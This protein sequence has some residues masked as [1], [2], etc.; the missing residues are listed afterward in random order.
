MVKKILI[1]ANKTVFPSLDG[2]SLAIQKLAIN[3]ACQNYLIDLVCVAKD[4]HHN[5]ISTDHKPRKNIRQRV[6]VK[7]MDL[8][9]I[10]F[11]KSIANK[12]SYQSLRFYD[13][14]IQHEI[15]KLINTNTYKAIVFESVFTTI[16]LNKLKLK[17]IEKIIFRAHNI[18]HKIWEDLARNSVFK[19]TIFLLL[20]KQIKRVEDAIPK[21]VDYIFTLSDSDQEYF[22]KIHPTKTIHIP[23]TFEVEKINTL[24]IT[25]SIAHLGAMDWKPNIEGID[26]FLE[27]VKPQIEDEDIKIYIAGKNMPKKYFKHQNT[28]TIIDG[29][30]DNAK[31]YI[32]NKE[33]IFV[34][35]FSGSGIRIKILE[36]MALGIPII[37]T[38]KG[39]HGIPYENKKNILIADNA[40]EFQEA[41]CLLIRNKQLAKNIGYEGQKLILNHFSH[42]SVNN[43]L[44]RILG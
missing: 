8:N 30:I 19:R 20:A 1:I 13:M 18:E 26:W 32:K 37:S 21:Y 35:L 33:I 14:K 15:Q 17:N 11:L 44:S 27:K 28:T 38:S 7:K 6:F 25:N 41:I 36:A 16:Y 40:C 23:V 24:K 34:P 31:D 22:N 29:K 3:L 4:N 12:Q 43:K 42:K 10:L 9:V 2:G 39:A 5:S